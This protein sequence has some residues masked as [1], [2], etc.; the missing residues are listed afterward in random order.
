MIQNYYRGFR[1]LY[2]QTGKNKIKLLME[3]EGVT[4]I[5]W[6]RCTRRIDVWEKI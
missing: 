6:Q 1:G 5:V 2:F 3:Y 4:Q